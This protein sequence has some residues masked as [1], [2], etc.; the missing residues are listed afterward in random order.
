M[1][2]DP[3]K[4]PAVLGKNPTLSEMIAWAEDNGLELKITIDRPMITMTPKKMKPAK[5]P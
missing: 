2:T 5:K 1:K 3:K 4:K